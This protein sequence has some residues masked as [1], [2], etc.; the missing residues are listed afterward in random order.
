MFREGV[1]LAESSA[2]ITKNLDHKAR[3]AAILFCTIVV[4]EACKAEQQSLE[5]A[6][7][8]LGSWAINPLTRDI[9]LC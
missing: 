3:P 2:L 8:F 7:N 9:K 4:L 5:C 1:N 6:K